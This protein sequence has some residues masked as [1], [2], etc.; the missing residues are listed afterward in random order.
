VYVFRPGVIQPL[1]GIKSRTRMYNVLYPVSYPLVLLL[2]LV[3]PRIITDTERV[4]QAMLGVARRGVP[5]KG[6]GEPRHQ[7]GREAVSH[8]A[9][10]ARRLHAANEPQRRAIRRNTSAGPIVPPA[11]RYA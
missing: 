11:P 10:A 6:A 3:A 9:G 4:G 1:H 2:K 7:R 8:A 5:Q